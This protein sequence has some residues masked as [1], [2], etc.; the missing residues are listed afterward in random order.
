M[1]ITDTHKATR[2]FDQ[3]SS[4]GVSPWT[5][6]L[7]EELR[8]ERRQPHWAYSLLGFSFEIVER[9]HSLSVVARFPAGGEMALQVGFCP[10]GDLRIEHIRPLD[11]GVHITALSLIGEYHVR[12]EFPSLDRPLLHCTSSLIPP[13]PLRMPF[14]PRDLMPVPQKNGGIDPEGK[15]YATQVGTRSGLVYFSLTQPRGGSALYFQDL[16]S[17][18]EYCRQTKTSLHDAVGGRWPELGLA[19]PTALDNPLKAEQE[20]VLSDVYMI[21]SPDEPD[22]DLAMSKQFL[23]F[24]AQIYLALPRVEG[25]YVHW[26]DVLKKCLRDLA[27]SSKCWSEEKGAYYLNA[28]VADYNTPP[29]SMVQL[30]VLLPLLEYAEWSGKEIPI[31]Q[32]ILAGLPRFFDRKAGVFGCWHTGAAVRL[33]RAEPQRKPEV[34]DSWYLYHSLLNIS[35][36]AR[37]GHKPAE[38]L[39]LQSMDYA[40]KVAH[41]FQYRWP[42]FYDIYTLRIVKAETTEGAGGEMDVAC[43]YTHVMLQAWRLTHEERFLTEAKKA[44]RSIRGLGFDL[45]YQANETVFGA[46]A[47]LALWKETGEQ[48]FLDLSYLCL[49]NI[50]NNV[51]LWE[52]K[53]GYGKH[54]ASFMALFPLKDA[55]YTAVY[56]ELE[57]FAALHDYITRHG[58]AVPEWANVLIPEYIRHFLNR[59]SFYYPPLLPKEVLSE[60]QRSGELDILLWIPVEDLHDGWEKAGEVGQ[61]VY[62]AGLPFALIPRHYWR[63]EK[64]RYAI[65]V[66]YPVE[67]FSTDKPGQAAFRVCGDS[68][69]CCRMRIMPLGKSRLPA[70]EVRTERN[71]ASSSLNA[72]ETPEGH[73]EYEL[74]GDRQVTVRW[75]SRVKPGSSKRRRK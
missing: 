14:W 70:F 18:N 3:Q 7:Q 35:R 65:Y 19:L 57:G 39:F 72:H 25:Q 62:G 12:L 44:A 30:T 11:N 54:Y 31:S 33:D 10:Y 66:E 37:R 49:A 73:L 21:F 60:K 64:G 75:N 32:D 52:F 4:V 42:V 55:P 41:K 17:L 38:R 1:D 45:F 40:V 5:M 24:L 63:I 67:K 34:M 47:M 68:R 15:V 43:L 53:Y 16:S 13:Q 2:G 56:E 28:Y 71:G 59:A 26:P 51:R 8:P 9:P 23:D 58:G 29:E 61:E 36:L 74:F 50:F 22:D 46:G 69:L 20:V 48:E 27:G 6:S